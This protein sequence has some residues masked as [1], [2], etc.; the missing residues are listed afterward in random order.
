MLYVSDGGHY[1]NL[2]MVELIRRRASTIW[3]IDASGSLPNSTSALVHAILLA[4]AETGC[5]I[6]IDLTR[7]DRDPESGLPKFAH[8]EG[9]IRYPDGSTATLKVIRIG[10]TAHHS[11][12][13]HKYALDDPGFP[14]HSTLRQVYRAERFEAYRRLGAES[15]QA[16]LADG[17][18]RADTTP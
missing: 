17:G 9:R 11:T 2:G 1:E 12:L 3:A 10:L 8:A 13:L 18:T 6:D 4:E 15:V 14:H 16:M 7:F 5:S